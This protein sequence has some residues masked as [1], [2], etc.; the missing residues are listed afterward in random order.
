MIRLPISQLQPGM[1]CAAPVRHAG[2]DSQVL[3][4]EN[5]PLKP[6]TISKLAG[7][8]IGTVWIRHPKFDFLDE[9]LRE[10]IALCRAHLHRVVREVFTGVAARTPGAFDP[11][12]CRTAVSNLIMALLANR[13]GAVLPERVVDGQQPLYDHCGN[14]AYLALVIGL[15]V[16]DYIFAE[17]RF[18]S[19][20][21]ATD[22]SNLGLGAMLHDLGKLG[23]DGRWQDVHFFDEEAGLDE[24]RAHVDRGYRAVQGR[25]EPT[26]SQTLLHHHQ[27]FD[28]KGFP[29][30]RARSKEQESKPIAGSAIH[31]FSRIVSVANT[32]DSLIG[33]CR[34][35]RQPTV[36]ALHEVQ[37]PDFAGAFDP[38]VLDAALRAIQPYPPGTYVELDDGRSA[39]VTSLRES[40]PCQPT[41]CTLSRPAVRS[42][43]RVE[44]LDLSQAGAPK[45][46]RTDG[47]SVGEAFYVLPEQSLKVNTEMPEWLRT[48][49]DGESTDV[50]LDVRR[51]PRRVWVVS[52]TVKRLSASSKRALTVRTL[53]VSR[54]GVGFISSE[55][56]GIGERIEF[57][58]TTDPKG[59][60]RVRVVHCAP[61][62]Q[63]YQT[64]CVFEHR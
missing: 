21:D 64:G 62:T 18:V 23:L 31:V 20:S 1:V 59:A 7:L 4:K 49:L 9:Q 6:E 30:P 8:G 56:L 61:I 32:I 41:V 26:A 54:T 19:Y 57:A 10:D 60:T 3:L 25:I 50:Q 14:T 42:G 16:K 43:P 47:V 38:V 29:E 13:K 24:Y 55:P 36:V 58:P 39:I 40:L 52:A 11:L 44:E 48:A 35:K 51:E 63:G 33:R 22:L 28:G 34:E 17:R 37:K 12:Q 15:S 2:S 45:I 27:R 53:N 46:V 5:Y